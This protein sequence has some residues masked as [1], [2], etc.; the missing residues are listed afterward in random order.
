MDLKRTLSCPE[1]R[2][3]DEHILFCLLSTKKNTTECF[4][5]REI[6]IDILSDTFKIKKIS[7]LIPIIKSI[8]KKNLFSYKNLKEIICSNLINEQKRGI[9][10][11]VYVSNFGSLY[12][13]IVAKSN[14]LYINDK[15][16]FPKNILNIE[17]LKSKLRI[18][19]YHKAEQYS[20]RSYC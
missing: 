9:F 3:I 15:A 17:I 11:F 2:Y 7:D 13:N 8:S 6:T 14:I 19:Y 12:Y 16:Y 18:S 5:D 10:D 20:I 4:F 1:F